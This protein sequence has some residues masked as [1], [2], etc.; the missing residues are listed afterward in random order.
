[1]C[2]CDDA[3]SIKRCPSLLQHCSGIRREQQTRRVCVGGGAVAN[4]LRHILVNEAPT[5]A[6]GHVFIVDNTSIIAVC[7]WDKEG[8]GVCQS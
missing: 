3:E 7:F 4:E 1:V 8:G 6:I 2:G 5:I